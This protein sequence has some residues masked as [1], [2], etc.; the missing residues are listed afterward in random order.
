[1]GT[2]ATVR[3]QGQ[4]NVEDLAVADPQHAVRQLVAQLLQ[5]PGRLVLGKLT[6]VVHA[7]P[8]PCC[9]RGGVLAAVVPEHGTQLRVPCEQRAYG[10]LQALRFDARAVELVVEVRG[11]AAELVLSAAPHPV[12][13][14]HQRQVEGRRLVGGYL[15]SRGGRGGRGGRGSGVVGTALGSEGGP[16]MQGRC[17]GEFGERHADPVPAQGAGHGHQ[18]DGVESLLDEVVVR[19]DALGVGIEPVGEQR[20]DRSQWIAF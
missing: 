3:Q 17:A 2:G 12:G 14:L 15:G 18:P 11:H 9:G 4:L 19:V 1:M 7:Q 6:Q 8:R 10:L 13:V 20:A 16:G 5:P